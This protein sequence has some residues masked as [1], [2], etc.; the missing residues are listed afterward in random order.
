MSCR[1]IGGL[2]TN[3]CTDLMMS[4][5]SWHCPDQLLCAYDI[6]SNWRATNIP[7]GKFFLPAIEIRPGNRIFL[8]IRGRDTQAFPETWSQS[9]FLQS[10]FLFNS[11]GK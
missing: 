2:S 10:A 11:R 6:V 1:Q 7:T 5:R 3:A 8:K 9:V 4:Q